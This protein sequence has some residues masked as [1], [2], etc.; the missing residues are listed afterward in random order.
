MKRNLLTL[1]GC[2]F[3]VFSWAQTDTVFWL[4]VPE[5]NNIH[6]S[7]GSDPAKKGAPGLIRITTS[8]NAATVKIELP[9]D[10]T[11]TPIIR[12]IPANTT[13]T[14][15]FWNTN[16]TNPAL[17][18]KHSD[19]CVDIDDLIN[20]PDAT[21]WCTLLNKIENEIPP[22]ENTLTNKG[23]RI[24]S[25][26][27]ITCYFEIAAEYNR[28][29]I[30]LKGQNAK[31]LEFYVPFQNYFDNQSSNAYKNAKNYSAIHIIATEDN[32]LVT[33]TP[34]KK[35]LWNGTPK[36]ANTPFDIFLSKAGQVAV[37]PPYSTNTGIINGLH[38]SKNGPDKL[39]GSY[40]KASN[41]IVV[42]TVDDLVVGK[43]SGNVDHIADQIVPIEICGAEY[44]VM[45]GQ[46]PAYNS[47]K[48]D[49]AYII[50][51]QDNTPLY[52]KNS[53]T[54]TITLA[55]AGDYYIREIDASESFVKINT[56]SDK[57]L[58][59]FH[60]SGTGNQFAG[61]ILP[62]TDRCTGSK[63]V[64]INR[65]ALQSNGTN[66]DFYL[67]LLVRQGG[68]GNFVIQREDGSTFTPA[69]SFTAVPGTNWS[70][71]KYDFNSADASSP[72]TISNTSFFHL[73][74]FLGDPG[75]DCF[76]GYFSDFN[77]FKPEIGSNGSYGADQPF[78]CVGS[79]LQL[80]ANGGIAYQWTFDGNTSYA[81]GD[82]NNPNPIVTPLTG[83]WHYYSCEIQSECYPAKTINVKTGVF[84]KVEAKL[85]IE[86]D[87]CCSPKSY[88]FANLSTNHDNDTWQF[89]NSNKRYNN[90][91]ALDTIVSN[92]G[93]AV[94]TETLVLTASN[95]G[96]SDV[97]TAF[98]TIKPLLT[99]K[100]QVRGSTGCNE[101]IDVEFD[102]IGATGPF[103][104]IEWIWGDGQTQSFPRTDP[105][106]DMRFTHTYTNYSDND[107]IYYAIAM[108]YDD[109]NNCIATGDTI[110][111]EVAGV[112]RARFIVS[113]SVGCSPHIVD[114]E[115]YSSGT[116]NYAWNY[117]QGT[118]STT[119]DDRTITYTN[120]TSLP[121][122]YTI[123]LQVE[124]IKSDG[125]S[126]FHDTSKV[127]T[128]YPEFETSINTAG[129]TQGCQ[130][131]LVDFSQTTTPN[132]PISNYNWDFN[133]G[134]G[135]G[136]S[137]PD[138]KYFENSSALDSTFMVSLITT[139]QYECKDTADPIA[140]TAYAMVDSRFTISDTAGCSPFLVSLDNVSSA[141]SVSNFSWNLDGGVGTPSNT[142]EFDITYTNNS[143]TLQTRTITLS[144]GNTHSEC[145]VQ[146][147]KQI[148]INPEFI[149]Q[150]NS[151]PD[152]ICNGESINFTNSSVF[153]DGI[154]TLINT[155]TPNVSFFWDFGD[156]TSSSS[157]NPSKQYINNGTTIK[158]HYISLSIS[159]NGCTETLLDS[160]YVQPPITAS[161]NAN[162]T[163]LCYNESIEI[164]NNSTNAAMFRWGFNNGISGFNSTNTN[165]YTYTGTNGKINDTIHQIIY[166]SAIT[167]SCSAHDT[168]TLV[169]YPEIKPVIEPDVQKGCAPL[170]IDFSNNTTGGNGSSPITFYWDFKD[171]EHSTS[172]ANSVQHTFAN[173]TT[174]SITFNVS[175]KATNTIGCTAQND[176]SIV[177]YPE[178]QAGFS[179]TKDG[180]CA[181]TVVNLNNNSLNGNKFTWDFNDPGIAD[182][183]KT[184]TDVFSTQLTS[185]SS[186]APTDFTITLYSKD[187]ITG[188]MGDSSHVVRIFP[189]VHAQFDVSDLSGCSP[190]QTSFTNNSSGYGLKYTWNYSDGESSDN[191]NTN[192]S[193][194]FNNKTSN[195]LIFPV[196]LTVTDTNGC[197]D[198]YIQNVE[199]YKEVDASFAFV[200]Q[201]NC[202]PI[203]VDFSNNS[204]NGS[205]FIWEFN[206]ASPDTLVNN[207]NIFTKQLSNPKLNDTTEYYIQLLATDDLTG[208]KD[209]ISKKIVVFP[210]VIA[211]FAISE[212]NG[213]SPLSTQFTNNSTG[214]GLSYFWD[215]NNGESS[216]NNAL[217]H[218]KNFENKTNSTKNYTVEL[219]ATDTNGCWAT[220]TQ[221]IEVFREVNAGF[222]F[223]KQNNCTPIT[224]NFHNSSLNG[225]K[226]SW[227]FNSAANDT[228][229]TA[230]ID[231][232]KEL[233]ALKLN[234][235]T[236]YNIEL[237]VLDETTG[238]KDSITKPIVVFPKVIANFAISEQN[239]CSP[240]STQFTNNSTGYGLSYFW[241]YNNGESSDNDNSTHSKNFSNKTN[242]NL[243]LDIKLTATDTNGCTAETN[244]E[245]EIFRE[246]NADF[247]FTKQSNCTPI[248]VEFNNSSLN[249]S[250]FSW[251]FNGAS[252]NVNHT[253]P[254]NFTKELNA[255][256]LNDTTI[257]NIELLV[258]DQAT[259]CTDSITKPIVVFPKVIADFAITTEDSGCSPLNTKFAN[260]SS[261]YG[262][263]F[264][265]DF[266]DE[267]KSNLKNPNHIFSNRNSTKKTFY[268]SLQITD[269][270]GCTSSINY[271]VTVYPEVEASF[272]MEPVTNKCT[273]FDLEIT[274]TALNGN[275]YFWD[276]GHKGRD[277]IFTNK[278]PFI[279]TIHDSLPNDTVTYFLEFMAKDSTYGCSDIAKRPLK[280]YPEV[281][282]NFSVPENKIGCAPL[283]SSINDM[284]TGFKLNYSWNYDDENTS[285]I[286]TDH[287]HTYQNLNTTNENHEIT[288]TVVDP[289]GCTDTQSET[290]TVYPQVIAG[291]SFMKDPSNPCTPYE[292][293]FNY[294][295]S[296]INGNRFFWNFGN[297]ENDTLTRSD[298]N[299]FS[300]TFTNEFDNT[301]RK[302]TIWQ[303]AYNNITGCKD[304]MYKLIEVYPI[305][306]PAFEPDTN[307]GCNPFSPEITN[308]STGLGNYEWE[309]GDGQSSPETSP[310]HKYEHLNPNPTNFNLTL[311]VEQEITGCSKELTKTITVN[312]YLNAK[313]GIEKDH[314]KFNEGDN[315][316]SESILGGCTPLNLIITDSSTLNNPN[317][318]VWDF[319]DGNSSTQITPG[320]YSF[321]NNDQDEPLEAK[322][323]TINLTLTNKEGCTK[324]TAK[325]V[326]VYP[327]STP[328]FE[329]A[330]FPNLSGCHPLDIAFSNISIDD[331]N[332]K[333]E[334][335]WG[336]GSNSFETSPKNK[337]YSN[338]SNTESKNY[339]V[340]L[341][342]TTSN[343]CIDSIKKS[344]TVFA[345]P[346]SS[347]ELS[348]IDRGCSPYKTNL[349]PTLSKGAN[350][351][352]W[353]YGDG[354]TSTLDNNSTIDKVYTNTEQD[355]KT[356]YPQLIVETENNCTDTSTIPV[357]IFQKVEANFDYDPEGCSPHDVTFHNTSNSPST[358]A[359]WSF[360]NGVGSEKFDSVFHRYINNN[361]NDKILQVQLISESIYGCR[362]TIEKPVTIFP[363]PVA[364]VFPEKYIYRYPDTVI[365]FDNYT[366]KGPFDLYAN[367][368]QGNIELIENLNAYTRLHHTYTGWGPVEFNSSIPL[369]FVIASNQ[370]VDTLRDTIKILPPIPIIRIENDAPY[371]C[372]PLEVDF[373][374][375]TLYS[376]SLYWNFG[377]G[378]GQENIR[379]PYHVFHEP[380]IYNIALNAIGDGGL[381]TAYQKVEVFPN[382]TPAFDLA[383]ENRIVMLPDQEMQF[384]NQS[385]GSDY[386]LWE[387]GDGE[388]STEEHTK[389]LYLEE[390]KFYIVLTAYKEYKQ[391]EIVCSTSTG[392]SANPI[393][394]MASGKSTFP[395]AFIPGSE[396]PADGTYPSPDY[397]NNV[398]HPIHDGVKE[399]EMWIYNRWGEQLFYSND[400]A[401]GWNGRKGGNGEALPEGVY[402]FRAKG[403]Y[404][405]GYPFDKHGD[406]TL[407]R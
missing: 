351:Y 249:G 46:A 308:L 131:F 251:D 176:T 291:F 259:G 77:D 350:L 362:D 198:N 367:W 335:I 58:V 347:F 80:N 75:A 22:T 56:D 284:S 162:K 86:K 396:S 54:P 304:S 264:L 358:N 342:S 101:E 109:I 201:S 394:V 44:I 146:F 49:A 276:F 269:T 339:I 313:F 13:Y 153:N 45:R 318:Y 151:F 4:S 108:F 382:P 235:T 152:T 286:S 277:S 29:I 372:A 7:G 3:Y 136:K 371:G 243:M 48:Q 218:T 299:E 355:I 160:V 320:G 296:A 242:N 221:D 25:D 178:V 278:A 37:I 271:P 215:Y 325:Q 281:N 85:S 368:G 19:W 254:I 163:N 124:R 307:R 203:N 306:V 181:P 333:Y 317:G 213:C 57:K 234:D 83:G 93:N 397:L 265:W 245:I 103:T 145:N 292:V 200:K 321:Y 398:F 337:N 273:P 111:T 390:G 404:E 51:A 174:D 391:G 324:T 164:T 70:A 226:F 12:N 175:L 66:L 330:N 250:L 158:K 359:Y 67:L 346:L 331:D 97:D 314:T 231:F 366:N 16:I 266:K 156:G 301:I 125:S 155:A 380:G 293:N 338:F 227:D 340:E 255:S 315:I 236:L 171:G 373:D 405:N 262:L 345:K 288:L 31:G 195:T 387:F 115:N 319:G 285:D 114:I 228:N 11:F 289:Q 40:I 361:P 50:A 196:E 84:P 378:T 68:E 74:T 349:N 357:Q 182:I 142:T 167:G 38:I 87:T 400:V 28:E 267:N 374:S 369:E 268:V 211:N 112:A 207:K 120:T 41:P 311:K 99:P 282:A 256:K 110:E 55:N 389:H 122:N 34:T 334:W 360:G 118:T 327:R 348:P 89:L 15:E 209:S 79:G 239:G 205:T 248:N 309:F 165:P 73:A 310:I 1:L 343:G 117:G 169:V 270:N 154:P 344:V 354:N 81:P 370:C 261:G 180:P 384:F 27:M 381:N 166:L 177:I 206:G 406:I 295:S 106:N 23:I 395:N 69:L 39:I 399:F 82:I 194:V 183:I 336:D 8:G 138:P 143:N 139:S 159:M 356:Y 233:N 244:H 64:T 72:Y 168:L 329:S 252:S 100:A 363:M 297:K 287:T 78:G 95:G 279:V 5:I 9:A 141:N 403:I 302:D 10:P 197:Q 275:K 61:A 17:S 129:A 32:T 192:H 298:K 379:E 199:V 290:V 364:A 92:S 98:L 303:L 140:I 189:E 123:Q 300:H 59:V 186:T 88:S 240:L 185:N 392:N 332:T 222:T 263:H 2:L 42:E 225:S 401:K 62:P 274:P 60:M 126:C 102:I 91:N 328:D 341:F 229:H 65:S 21:R 36:P 144:N 219:T 217:N 258:L 193:K 212:Q 18:Y 179:F 149:A 132:V 190:F 237:L 352:H 157:E 30:A 294:P 220:S 246:V 35:V 375:Y 353:D 326:E 121:V 187:T 150:I 14:Y 172:S 24:R 316:T 96:C 383:P 208:C 202:T 137:N 204:L 76:Y 133:D 127:I 94:Y 377:D 161:L 20:C 365:A 247:T 113:D 393:S 53:A 402:F 26:N 43:T 232:T 238:C 105:V 407:L 214:Y 104:R 147:T 135:S 388:T 107:T 223:V 260:T 241:D 170:N 71:A 210:K 216:D 257:Y 188:C 52:F 6:W 323:Y 134:S 376:D 230:P 173:K 385:Q 253:T 63:S 119:G 128:V 272:V 116:V 130:P 90:L 191:H 224:V 148:T 386:Y 280:V 305:L 47:T 33:V 322:F 312:S 184:N 283:K